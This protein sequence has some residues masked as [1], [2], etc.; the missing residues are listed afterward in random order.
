[1]DAVLLTPGTVEAP[2]W[3][4]A[5]FAAALVAAL[6]ALFV[7]RRRSLR[8]GELVRIDELTGLLNRRG[9]I[10]TL[11]REMARAA[12]EE[13]S[14]SVAMLD[15]DH[16]KQLND[17]HGHDVGDEALR[18]VAR[19][20]G[21]VLRDGD[22]IG[23]LG[24]DEFGVL[25][26][27]CSLDAAP[28]VL[29]RLRVG[30][31][32]GRHCSAGVVAWDGVEE[33]S[34]LLRRADHALYEAKAAGGSCT[35]RGLG[36]FLDSDLARSVEAPRTARLALE[37][38]RDELPPDTYAELKLLVSELVTNS[39]R[40][41]SG[42]VQMRVWLTPRVVRAEVIDQGHGFHEQVRDNDFAPRDDGGGWGLQLL[43]K[44]SHRWG[45][46]AGSTHV[47]FEL[48]R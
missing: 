42:P 9:W 32:G 21:R 4:V 27:S 46:Y 40:Y 18:A 29:D 48:K 14:L 47:W 41:G 26:T 24:G 45:T 25:L 11:D 36:T 23:R 15:L 34:D 44:V 19:A 20:A 3:T 1:M 13:T 10:E 12:R 43:E 8:M 39:V 16:F 17:R 33:A 2:D 35:V 38:L 6:A 28:E 5:V 22:A 30:I 7:F 37:P 31:G